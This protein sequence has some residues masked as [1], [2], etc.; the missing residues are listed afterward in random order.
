MFH[1]LCCIVVIVSSIDIYWLSKNRFF[2]IKS[3][4][5]KPCLDEHHEKFPDANYIVT[6]QNPIGRYLLELD[7]GDVSLFILLMYGNG[8]L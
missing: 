8:S 2:Y 1:L 6:E 4:L 3:Y 5:S 7:G